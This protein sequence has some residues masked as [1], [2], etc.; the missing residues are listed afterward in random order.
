MLLVKTRLEASKIHGVGVFLLEPIKKGQAV[1]DDDP[2][3]QIK[4]TPEEIE[5]LPE[6]LYL[7][8]EDYAWPSAPDR[9]EYILTI[10]NEKYMNHS[11][12]PNV[13]QNGYAMRDI[14]IGEELTINYGGIDHRFEDEN[15]EHTNFELEDE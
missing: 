3:A 6:A 1:T 8:I 13:D 11:A 2:R 7:F 4:F 15:F 14:A 12:Q 10:D 9:D 5:E